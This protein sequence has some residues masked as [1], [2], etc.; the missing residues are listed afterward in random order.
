MSL[1]HR[2]MVALIVGETS[3]ISVLVWGFLVAEVM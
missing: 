2:R 1:D 3:D